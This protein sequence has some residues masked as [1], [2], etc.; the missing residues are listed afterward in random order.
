MQNIPVASL[1]RYPYYNGYTIKP[2]M[3]VQGIQVK[4]ET[5]KSWIPLCLSLHSYPKLF[6]KFI[7]Y[8]IFNNS[9]NIG[10]WNISRQVVG[11]IMSLKRKE[12][13]KLKANSHKDN[14]YHLIFSNVLTSDSD[15][16]QSNTHKGWCVLNATECNYKLRSVIGQEDEFKV[17]K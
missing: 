9:Y 3:F 7:T 5:P 8:Y 1:Q 14:K 10:T 13:M 17:T 6:Y 12:K 15:F 4:L 16:L 2:E 11:Y